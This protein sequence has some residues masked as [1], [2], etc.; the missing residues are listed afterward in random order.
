MAPLAL[1]MVGLPPGP[2]LGWLTI[3]LL[4][5]TALKLLEARSLPERRLVSLLQLLTAGLLAALRPELG[6]SLLQALACLIA[7]A[8]LLGLELEEGADGGLLLRRS[9]QLLT[10]ALPV[11]LVLFLLLPQLP[12]L[13]PLHT[14]PPKGAV[15]GL[16]PVLEPGAIAELAASDAPA[17][18]VAFP[19]GE[20]PPP[21]Q[22]YW[23]VLVHDRFDG[24]S[25]S[26]PTPSDR[27]QE[28]R[29]PAAPLGP[30][31]E[32]WQEEPSG[33][34]VVPWS[35]RGRPLGQEL[36]LE[37]NGELRHRAS[38]DRRRIY[39]LSGGGETPAWRLEPASDRDLELP[40]SGDPRLRRLAAEWRDLGPPSLRLRAAERWFR[41]QPFRYTL[42]PGSLPQRNPLD[43]FLFERQA[44][45]CGHYASAFTVL[46][47]AAGVP[48]RVVSGYRGG[49]W[50][51]ALGGTGY[52]D[53]RRSDAHAWSEVWLAGEG[54]L[55]VDPTT[56]ISG[57][58]GPA[59]AG[60]GTA[61]PAAG[62]NPQDWLLRQWWG[63]D[64]AW[65][66]WW[67]GFDREQQ[68]AL[69]QR[70]L[71]ER[72][73]WLGPLVLAS[74]AACLAGGL[75]GLAWL[76]RRKPQKDPL[77]RELDRWLRGCER[78]GLEPRAGETLPSFAA[79]VGQRWPE[80]VPHL[81]AFVNLYQHSRY[82][83][84]FPA[85][86]ERQT[87]RER[88]RQLQQLRRQRRRLCRYLQQLPA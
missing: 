37:R 44:G 10:A 21:E 6:P 33:L 15:T 40:G 73:E 71:G 2:P 23:R 58:A 26:G 57:A 35:G 83:A 38:A 48:A 36:R 30:M 11:A 84:E 1:G 87:R 76:Q 59:T 70:L 22:R 34:A 13:I 51:E 65:T 8:G 52:L 25:W 88:R 17:A 19:G 85:Q 46:M 49:A 41:R 47:R 72:T 64:L 77:R 56:W 32:L 7:L 42:R 75:A 60:L 18:R 24:R 86:G 67:L 3:V 80:L 27:Q 31:G 50:V 16:N 81:Q 14:G 78:R 12:P 29:D 61:A 68:Q 20:P 53:L 82:G 9:L 55:R 4:V 74:L 66:R 54:W 28:A 69:L 5:V 79:R 45:F 62:R 43:A 63:L 39:G